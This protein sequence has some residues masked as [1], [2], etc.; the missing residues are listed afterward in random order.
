MLQLH[1][2]SKNDSEMSLLNHYCDENLA[3]L[4]IVWVFHGQERRVFLRNIACFVDIAPAALT[5]AP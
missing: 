3:P 5:S 4:P 2:M 1:K